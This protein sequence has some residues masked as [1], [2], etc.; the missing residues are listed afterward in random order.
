MKI[1]VLNECFLNN[2]YLERLKKIGEVKVF[3]V[4]KTEEDAIKRLKGAD[5]AIVDGFE[6][7]ISKNVLSSTKLKLL[8]LPH[9][10]F[11]MVDFKTVKEKGITVVN[12]PG[13]SL[14]SV[15]EMAI[16]LIFAVVKKIAWVD[17]LMRENPFSMDPGDRTLDKFWGFNLEGKTL[18]IIGLGRIGARVAELAQGLGMKVV[19]FNRTHKKVN[20][21]TMLNLRD[22]LRRSDVISINLALNPET[23]K[24]ISGKQLKLMKSKAILINCAAAKHVDTEA[25]YDALKEGRIGGAGLDIIDGLIKDHPILKLDNVVFTPHL[26]SYTDESFRKNLPEIVTSNIEAFLNRKPQNVVS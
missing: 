22:L 7:P 10:S 15:A 19:A 1:A 4:T 16:G 5:I 9:N 17:R 2:S 13:F 18:G 20:G 3:P 25:L 21:V 11:A 8:V 26:A 24:F 6:C 23:E 12:S 14:Q